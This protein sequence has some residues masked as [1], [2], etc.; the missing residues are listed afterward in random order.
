MNSADVY[1]Y[2]QLHGHR[3]CIHQLNK[4]V[5]QTVFRRNRLKKANT[6]KKETLAC[7]NIR[8]NK[9]IFNMVFHDEI[10]VNYK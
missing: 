8:Y 9:L 7:Y 6:K 3:N 1:P 10:I 2:H 4:E 5:H